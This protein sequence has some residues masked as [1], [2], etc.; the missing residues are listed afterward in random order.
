VRAQRIIGELGKMN[1]RV[2]PAQMLRLNVT[3]VACKSERAVLSVFE[4]PSGPIQAIVEPDY[5]ITTLD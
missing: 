1:N 3:N 2:E 5:F 4:Q